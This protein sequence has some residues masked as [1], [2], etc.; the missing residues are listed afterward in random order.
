MGGWIGEN[1]EVERGSRLTGTNGFYPLIHLYIP[2]IFIRLP[3][4]T[5]SI[6]GKN[7]GEGRNSICATLS[8][9]EESKSS[10][11]A[12]RGG[13][14]KCRPHDPRL[15]VYRHDCYI[16]HVPSAATTPP[17]AH[18]PSSTPTYIYI[19]QYTMFI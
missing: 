13:S 6:C 3:L 2:F 17:H 8:F 11:K 5:S 12:R 7:V 4:L 19:L 14:L 10:H 16:G 18:L 9:E 15:S 1:P